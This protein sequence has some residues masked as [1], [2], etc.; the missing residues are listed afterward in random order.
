MKLWPERM[1]KYLPTSVLL[2]QHRDCAALRGTLWEK[3]NKAVGYVFEY[4]PYLLEV[5]HFKV[6]SL[7]I[8]RN[9]RVNKDWNKKGYRG[10]KERPWTPED[11]YG[12]DYI[13][14]QSIPYPKSAAYL[15]HTQEYWEACKKELARKKLE[16][17]KRIPEKQPAKKKWT[18]KASCGFH[19]GSCVVCDFSLIS[20]EDE[21]CPRCASPIDSKAP[22]EA[23]FVNPGDGFDTHFERQRMSF[24]TLRLSNMQY[25]R[26][27]DPYWRYV[28]FSDRMW[29]RRWLGRRVK[30]EEEVAGPKAEEVIQ[31]MRSTRNPVYAAKFLPYNMKPW[32]RKRAWVLWNIG[33][34]MPEGA[35]V[36]SKILLPSKKKAKSWFGGKK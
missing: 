6:L 16:P 18:K 21:T 1:L 19:I 13:H 20:D 28:S 25:S 10:E 33:R 31:A 27:G 29:Y 12:R 22:P 17:E 15:E 30:R 5:Y 34:E 11:L 4:P 8:S 26:K 32:E 24:D 3:K 36:R 7:L 2:H 14:K 35:R 9:L 23:V